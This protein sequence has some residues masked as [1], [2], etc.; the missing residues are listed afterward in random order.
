MEKF[1]KPG[2]ILWL[3]KIYPILR[4]QE[5]SIQFKIIKKQISG[6]ASGET[7]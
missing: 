1:I 3:L 2:K 5:P 6:S 7:H 4:F